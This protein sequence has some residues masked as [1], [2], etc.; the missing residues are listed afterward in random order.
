MVSYD[1]K[2]LYQLKESIEKIINY[3]TGINYDDF[4]DN[5]QIQDAVIRRFDIISASCHSLSDTLKFRI[6]F[7]PWDRIISIREKLLFGEF[8]INTIKVWEIVKEDLPIF[9]D[10]INK[11]IG[12]L[13]N[14]IDL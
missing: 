9:R 11:I 14:Y 4:R 3:T 10:D 6:D 1:I 5:S 13:R 7:I 8:E 12:S 2:Y